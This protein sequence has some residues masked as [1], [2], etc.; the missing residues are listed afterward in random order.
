LAAFEHENLSLRPKELTSDGQTGW[1]PANDHKVRLYNCT[2]TGRSEILDFQTV[3][4]MQDIV[5][6]SIDPVVQRCI[7]PA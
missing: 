4:P 5:P 6:I 3:S 7:I 2:C 1:A